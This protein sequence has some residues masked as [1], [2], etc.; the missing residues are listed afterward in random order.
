MKVISNTS[1]IIGLAKL[2]RLGLLKKLFGRVLLP[3]NVYHEFFQ[4]CTTTEESHF[5]SMCQECFE[6]VDVDVLHTF[7]RQLGEGEKSVLTL[8]LQEQADI[9]LLDDRKACNEAK[10]HQLVVAST[11]AILYLAEDRGLI[12]NS[13][14]T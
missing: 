12:A 7:S 6:I 5:Q 1:P 3:R 14:D 4:N 2:E 11:R 9:V 10:E 8:A 13:E